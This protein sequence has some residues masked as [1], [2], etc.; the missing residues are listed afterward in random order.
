[1]YSHVVCLEDAS[2]YCT[3]IT[4]ATAE[5][6]RTLLSSRHMVSEGELKVH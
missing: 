6:L 2:Y 4:T 3:G 5:H 1:M